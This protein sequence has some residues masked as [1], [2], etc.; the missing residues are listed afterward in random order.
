MH[1]WPRLCGARKITQSQISSIRDISVQVLT[2]NPIMALLYQVNH[3]CVVWSRSSGQAIRCIMDN[4][5]Y[6]E[7]TAFDFE[8]YD[9]EKIEVHVDIGRF[10]EEANIGGIVN[11]YTLS[12]LN[13]Q[14]LKVAISVKLRLFKEKHLTIHFGESRVILGGYYGKRRI[15]YQSVYR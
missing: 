10:T 11:M 5:P 12:P 4:M 14:G 8:L 1:L 7:K 3:I 13:Y 2:F 15:L 6:L 9:L